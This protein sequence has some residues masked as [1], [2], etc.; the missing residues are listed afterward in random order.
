V[1]VGQARGALHLDI[2]A[3][4]ACFALHLAG[5][6]LVLLVAAVDRRGRG[7]VG[8]R[9]GLGL[10]R[11]FPPRDLPD[12]TSEAFEFEPAPGP[13]P[14]GL[15]RPIQ[16]PQAR[17]DG[18]LVGL[19]SKLVWSKSAPPAFDGSVLAVVMVSMRRKIVLTG[20]RRPGERENGMATRPAACSK[21]G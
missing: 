9:L 11:R 6:L 18:A 13:L 12:D 15:T 21:G 2:L 19:G 1:A 3:V 7:S 10:R 14:A 20:G 5:V 16:R 17:V 4:V 8:R